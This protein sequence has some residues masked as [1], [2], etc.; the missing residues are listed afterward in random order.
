MSE[1]FVRKARHHEE[2]LA[3]IMAQ[4]EATIS[5]NSPIF[6]IL[7]VDKWLKEHAP[8]FQP[9]VCNK[10]MHHTQLDVM[11][12]GGPNVREDFHLNEGEELF[13]Q[14]KG[15]ME[16]VVEE[17]G[18]QRSIPIRE[19]EIFLLPGKIPH[20]PRRSANSIGLVIE[21]KRIEGVETDGLRYYCKDKKT[22]LYQ[23]VFY[24]KDLGLELVPIIKE[25]FASEEYATGKPKN[26]SVMNLPWEIDQDIDLGHPFR[27]MDF[28]DTLTPGCHPVFP[29]KHQMSTN[30][31]INCQH[32]EEC[33]NINKWL[34]VIEGQTKLE[35]GQ[36]MSKGDSVLMK[37]G[38]SVKVD[39][40]G[41]LLIVSQER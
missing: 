11:F 32:T 16:L 2:A 26:D 22:I 4:M 29:G 28:L 3:K 18:V 12:V 23:K 9:P 5:A 17:K 39:I 7:N 37:P 38:Q 30:V 8:S 34:Y 31:A 33:G 36:V 24:C 27:F 10:L 19:G 1:P 25:Y 13:W 6:E 14:L 15:E 21:R 20:S 41:K 35:N 40:N